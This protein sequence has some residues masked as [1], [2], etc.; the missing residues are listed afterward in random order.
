MLPIGWKKINQIQWKADFSFTHPSFEGI[1]VL[2]APSSHMEMGIPLN[3]WDFHLF[4]ALSGL[5]WRVLSSS[6]PP[7][8]LNWISLGI[9]RKLFQSKKKFSRWIRFQD[10][11]KSMDFSALPGPAP[12]GC[13]CPC[14][15]QQTVTHEGKIPFFYYYFYFI[16]PGGSFGLCLPIQ[17]HFLTIP[18][19]ISASAPG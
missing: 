4:P 13:C 8:E 18:W 3:S 19:K 15:A 16:S 17:S 1:C 14:P 2:S 10:L 7:V 9:S 5:N 12:P 11:S 6:L